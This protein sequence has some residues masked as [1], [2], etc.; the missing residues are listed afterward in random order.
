[1]KTESEPSRSSGQHA[2]A[3]SSAR[4]SKRLGMKLSPPQAELLAAMQAGVICHYM[5]HGRGENYYFRS[6]TMRHCTAQANALRARGLVEPYAR[7]WRGHKLRATHA[8]PEGQAVIDGH[9]AKKA[10]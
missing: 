6:D 9:E 4:A 7:D 8:K 10:G 1:M 5:M 3:T 2:A